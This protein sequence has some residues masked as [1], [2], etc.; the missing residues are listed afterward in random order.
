MELHNYIVT[1]S[2]LITIKEMNFSNVKVSEGT[3]II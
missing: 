3:I 1:L 2:N